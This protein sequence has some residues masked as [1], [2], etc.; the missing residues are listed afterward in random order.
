MNEA[1]A[2]VSDTSE[3]PEPEAASEGATEQVEATPDEA[4]GVVEQT[5]SSPTVTDEAPAEGEI[6]EEEKAPEI[7]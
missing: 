2:V 4:E 1:E 7:L 3:T 6:I 5:E